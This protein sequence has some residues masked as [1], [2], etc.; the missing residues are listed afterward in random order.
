MKAL[1]FLL[2]ASL[3]LL[4]ALGAAAADF[5]GTKPFLCAIADV[6][7]CEPSKSCDRE[8]AATV[9]APQ[10]FVVDVGKKLVSDIGPGSIG[11]ASKIDRV[12]HLGGLLMLSGVDAGQGWMANI[13]EQSGKLTY[14]V[15]GDRMVVVAF[16]ACLL[17]P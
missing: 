10:F 6:S 9:N 16:G 5:D 12:D 17:R 4:P 1:S 8:S 14:T 13:V 15:T 11:R 2:S 3:A 7:S